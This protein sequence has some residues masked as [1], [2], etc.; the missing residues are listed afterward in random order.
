MLSLQD[1]INVAL[2]RKA[3][4]PFLQPSIRD[5]AA[6]LN[7]TPP[8]SVKDLIAALNGLPAA[9]VKFDSGPLTAGYLHGNGSLFIQSDGAAVFSGSVNEAGITGDNFTFAAALLDVKDDSGNVATF[10]HQD[11]V[12]GQ[13]DIGFSNKQWD[14]I[15]S[16]QL[17]SDKWDSVR[18]SRVQWV[19]LAKTDPFEVPETIINSIVA[20][21]VAIGIIILGAFVIKQAQ[22]CSEKNLWQ[23]GYWKTDP[24]QLGPDFVPGGLGPPPDAE[25]GY[26]YG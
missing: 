9:S 4:P 12:V 25:S 13:I 26:S 3:V 2:D 20:A 1:S 10:I 5:L 18:S 22:N 11:T 21:L 7:L 23:C 17:L 6:K 24:S 16:N 8:I 19:L 14:T 15:G